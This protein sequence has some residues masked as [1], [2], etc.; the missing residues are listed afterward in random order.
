MDL[1]GMTQSVCPT[2]RTIV[3]AKV[4]TDGRDVYFRKFCPQH[5]EA[6]CFVRSNLEDYLRSQHYVKPAWMP[7]AFAGNTKADCPA[8]CGF[9]ERHEQHLCMP[10]IEITSRCDLDCPV[11]LVNAGAPWDMTLAEFRRLLDGLLHAERQIDVLNLS[12]GEPLLHPQLIEF[13]DEA[14]SRPEIV[15][16]SISTNGL[17]LLAD[18]A[19]IAALHRRNVC[20]SLQFDGF[21]DRACIALRGRPLLREKLGILKA[22]ESDGIS[23]SLT[24][25]AATGVNDDQFPAMLDYLF[26]HDHVVSMMIQPV[27]Y[28]GRAASMPAGA[29]RLTIPDVVKALGE[30]G[31]PA[32]A[33]QDF[34]PLPC[35]HP[36]CFSMAF[37]LMLDGGGAVSVSR[38]VNA[39]EMMDATR[40]RVFFGLAADELDRL[41]RMVYD[42][43]SAPSGATPD[44]EAVMKTVRGLL[45]EASCGCFDARKV[46]AAA[47]RRVKSIF[48]HAF[49]DADT[50]DLARVRRCC[51]AYPQ[52]D[53]RLMPSCVMNVLRRPR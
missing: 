48:I 28:A 52:P 53:G 7:M 44:S 50:F 3:P 31:H 41:K 49:Q 37:Y 33:S 32:V 27:A 42:L 13:V 15:R 11:C 20:V 19:L 22:L 9:C 46:F 43:W 23:T 8:G 25:T 6:T 34:V 5:G 1:L 45:R 4:L 24:M 10:I 51:N 47:E 36:L 14:V 26:G 18:P 12:G 40:N 17:T 29:R 2:C 30:A 39:S 21:D 16:V 38:L 35:S